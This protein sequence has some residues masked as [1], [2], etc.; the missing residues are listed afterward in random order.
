M[1]TLR[2]KDG[3]VQILLAEGDKQKEKQPL[4]VAFF[5]ADNPHS[6]TMHHFWGLWCILLRF[7]IAKLFIRGQWGQNGQT[8]RLPLPSVV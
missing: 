7:I 3:E 2:T 6:Y 5:L 4:W 1:S 8:A